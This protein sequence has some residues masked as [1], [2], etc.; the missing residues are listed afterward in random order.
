MIE[1]I[2]ADRLA[3]QLALVA[4]QLDQMPATAAQAAAAGVRALTP[5]RTGQLVATVTGHTT[6]YGIAVTTTA[7]YARP[8]E[9]HQPYA[10]PGVKA[11]EPGW[12]TAYDTAIQRLLDSI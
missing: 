12:L 4:A 9:E 3:A 8:V 1:V 7:R 6:T 2:G 5:I 11:T 10:N